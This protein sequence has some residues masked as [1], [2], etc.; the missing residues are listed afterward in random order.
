MR[1]IGFRAEKDGINWAVVEGTRDAPTLVEHDFIP[2]PRSS[3]EAAALSHFRD[4]VVGVVK[5]L[6]P[7]CGLG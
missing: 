5:R 6:G 3:S 7:I 4:R 2:T 1:A